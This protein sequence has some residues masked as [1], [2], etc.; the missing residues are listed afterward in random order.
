M[1]SL[2]DIYVVGICFALLI[3]LGMSDFYINNSQKFIAGIVFWPIVGAY[4]IIYAMAWVIGGGV[5]LL[6][7]CF[8]KE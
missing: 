8:R 4:F 1:E 5:Q 6:K 3:S 7:D 2:I